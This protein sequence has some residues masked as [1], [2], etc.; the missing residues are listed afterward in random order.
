MKRY[1][2]RNVALTMLIFFALV[3][4]YAVITGVCK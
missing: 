1:D 4:S 3:L 2:W